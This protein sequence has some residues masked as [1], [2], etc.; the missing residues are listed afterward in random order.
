[1]FH[2]SGK[3][4]NKKP[5]IGNKMNRICLHCG[6]SYGKHIGQLCPS[7]PIIDEEIYLQTFVKGNI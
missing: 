3:S 2:D 6:Y 4:I 1:M 5:S 7:A